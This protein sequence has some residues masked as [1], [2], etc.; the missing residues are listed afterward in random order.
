MRV[1]LRPLSHNGAKA[2]VWRSLL[3]VTQSQP[4][5]E[6]LSSWSVDGPCC[7]HLPDEAGF[8]ISLSLPLLTELEY[9]LTCYC[10]LA[11]VK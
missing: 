11:V 6:Y 4:P 1:C 10:D 5:L 2:F 7:L 8:L 9:V 3:Q